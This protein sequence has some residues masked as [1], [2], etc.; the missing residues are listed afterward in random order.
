[1]RTFFEIEK[2]RPHI[3]YWFARYGLV[4]KKAYAEWLKSRD[5]DWKNGSRIAIVTDCV[6]VR[7]ELDTWVRDPKTDKPMAENDHHMAALK[8]IVGENPQYWGDFWDAE[9][10]EKEEAISDEGMPG[11]KYI[12]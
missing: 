7:E 8:Y 5:G 12:R 6:H 2:E 11:R 1:M 10:L 9:K 3:M 4:T